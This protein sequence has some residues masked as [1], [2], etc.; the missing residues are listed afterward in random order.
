MNK[1][2]L[3]LRSTFFTFQ[4]TVFIGFVAIVVG[5][6]W[7][8][9]RL[10]HWNEKRLWAMPKS[11]LVEMLKLNLPSIE[12]DWII[13]SPY[14]IIKW[15]PGYRSHY[16]SC[17]GN[18]NMEVE[19]RKL[20]ASNKNVFVLASDHPVVQSFKGLT[21]FFPEECIVE[22]RNIKGLYGNTVLYGP[23]SLEEYF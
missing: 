4:L 5:N 9:K 21:R 6:F 10:E 11:E 16:H 14:Q 15:L 19:L 12:E 23:F 22:S 3:E 20:I 13:T 17:L 2:F 18:Q 8:D 1:P 7:T